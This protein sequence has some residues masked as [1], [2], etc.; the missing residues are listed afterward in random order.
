MKRSEA[1]TATLGL[2][3]I[4][5]DTPA[6]PLIFPQGKL[7]TNNN[8]RGLTILLKPDGILLL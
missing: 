4:S 1:G 6:L 7:K 2:G 5:D 8:A 3:Q